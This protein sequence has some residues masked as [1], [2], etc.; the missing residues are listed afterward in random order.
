[1]IFI[2]HI[3][4][5][6]YRRFENVKIPFKP[7]TLI[8]GE[9]NTGKT[10][11]L[12]ILEFILSPVKRG[13]WYLTE[14]DLSNNLET[15]EALEVI[16]DLRSLNN[17][18]FDEEEKLFFGVHVEI[19]PD[20]VERLLL[21]LKC[22]REEETGDFLCQVFYTKEDGMEEER[23]R[24]NEL[25]RIPF[26]LIPALRN[27]QKDLVY[28][29]GLWGRMLGEV[30]I[31]PESREEIRLLA[32]EVAEQT[33]SIILGEE[34]ITKVKSD[35]DNLFRSVLWSR[36][37]FGELS[38]SALPSNHKEFLQTLQI[39]LRNPGD[40]SVF[41][42]L[43][44]GEGTQSITV[45][46]LMISY[47]KSIGYREPIIA[48]E[49]PE[50][51]LHPH[52]TR[53][54]V[55][56]LWSIPHQVILTTHST[57]VANMV[58]PDQIVLLK[59]KG[60][61]TVSRY[62]PEGYFNKKEIR[63]IGRYVRTSG[64]EMYFAKC[65]LL[66]EGDT[67][68]VALPIFSKALGIDLDQLGIS[69][70]GVSGAGDFSLL[71]RLL[72]QNSLDIPSYI[73]CDNDTAGWNFAFEMKK[74]GLINI[75]IEGEKGEVL[76]NNLE[77]VGVFV[78]PSGNFEQ[79]IIDQGYLDAYEKAISVVFGENKLDSYIQKREREEND[80]NFKNS[81]RSYKVLK[82]ISKYKRKPELAIEV[83]EILSN[84]D[85]GQMHIPE[86]FKKVLLA[87]QVLAKREIETSSNLQQES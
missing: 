30:N 9:N 10:S 74:K 1:M 35:F 55:S 4:L 23:V 47:A 45:I 27:A 61:S 60:N 40:K 43:D 32:N 8:L 86:Y 26:F 29:S 87:M 65:V 77:S 54:L 83:A 11:L 85:S 15:G 71:A 51:H 38:F 75:N 68:R 57:E 7:K 41:G 25:K 44:H 63:T 56:Y 19:P 34:T 2:H 80:S 33:M 18:Q 21:K 31:S 66:V 48:V 67:E 78:L 82:F 20:G 13:G 5:K 50:N 72:H 76:R 84:T 28:K 69:V 16:L 22:F 62:I 14:E 6:N 79:Y 59:R 24:P 36:D 81:E 46:F 37:S 42:I 12:S 70:I 39:L 3:L 64:S 17:D 73:M 49:E 52:S 58:T 53:A